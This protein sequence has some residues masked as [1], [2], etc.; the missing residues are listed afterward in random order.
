MS[1]ANVLAALAI[2]GAALVSGLGCGASMTNRFAHGPHLTGKN[3]GGP[4]QPPCATC[5]TCHAGVR[6]SNDKA[7]PTVARCASCHKSNAGDDGQAVTVKNVTYAGPSPASAEVQASRAI[8]FS[9][10]SHMPRP[11]IREQCV[12]C[13]A[14]A[15]DDG[16][17]GA[18]YPPMDKCL[19]CHDQGFAQ[20]D[21]RQCHK[22]NDLT[23]LRPQTFLRHDVAFFR[24]HGTKATQNQQVCTQCHSQSWCNDCHDPSQ[25]LAVETRNMDAIQRE[26]VHRADFVTRHSIEARSAI[27]T[28]QRCHQP[29]YCDSC[30]VARGVSGGAN[31]SRNPHPPG[32]VGRDTSNPSFHGRAA[33]RDIVTCAACHD[34]G[35]A[36]NCILC[37]RV[38]GSGGNPHPSGWSSSRSPQ[39][40]MCRY[41]HAG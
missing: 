10:K 8:V 12:K 36:T 9:H 2:V 14:G 34:Q 27:A 26:M 6:E 32:W 35:P 41:C 40:A 33:K 22:A 19:G 30:H 7:F 16:A 28:C 4:D 18:M 17:S 15:P 1:R 23:K 5:M 11:G 3:C 21:C 39:S 24:D 31:G 13:H 38:G 37:H 20:G 25:T 29:S